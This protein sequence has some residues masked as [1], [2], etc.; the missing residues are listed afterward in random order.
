L[1][2]GERQKGEGGGEKGNEEETCI[3]RRMRKRRKGHSAHAEKGGHSMF[4]FNKKSVSKAA[5][6]RVTIP[7]K[8]SVGKGMPDN[9]PSTWGKWQRN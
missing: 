2:N 1:E 3:E 8:V 4:I 9:L 7:R 6:W 5:S